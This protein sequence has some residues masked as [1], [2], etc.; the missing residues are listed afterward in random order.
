MPLLLNPDLK[1][2]VNA[3]HIVD[4][5]A[6]VVQKG[7]RAG[8]ISASGGVQINPWP[9]LETPRQNAKLGDS[10]RNRPHQQQLVVELTPGES[11]HDSR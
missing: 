11:A 6:S 3:P 2:S 7:S 10:A 1:A 8:S 9:L 5:Q 4:S